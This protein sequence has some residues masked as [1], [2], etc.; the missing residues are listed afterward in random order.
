MFTSLLEALFAELRKFTRAHL[1]CMEISIQFETV[2]DNITNN[3]HT[4]VEAFTHSKSYSDQRVSKIMSGHFTIKRHLEK[5]Q[6]FKC[7]P[8]LC[9]EMNTF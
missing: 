4:K 5:L 1:L 7:K 2:H 8:L 9:M 6:T 3:G